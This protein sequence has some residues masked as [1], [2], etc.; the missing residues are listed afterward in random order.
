MRSNKLHICLNLIA[1]PNWHAGNI[2]IFNI[3]H[4]I[5]KLPD[6]ERSLVKLSIATR[7]LND[8]P[9]EIKHKVDKIYQEK[10]YHLIFYKVLR[11][12]PAF[13]RFPFFNF[14]SIDFYYPGG[15]LPKKWIF[16]WGGWIPD[17]QYRY[18]PQLFSKEEYDSRENRNVH[19]AKESPVL[20]FSSQNA[21]SDYHKFFPQYTGNEFLLRF[22]S[23]TNE[24]WLRQD[25]ISIQ[26]KYNLPDQFFIVCNQFWKHKDHPTIIDAIKILKDRGLNIIVVC[27]GATEDFRN[28]DY[29]PSLLKKAKELGVD[30]QFKVLGFI[31]RN[32]QIQLIRRSLAIIQPSL[33]EG[34]STVV[35][36]GRAL[37]KSIFLS[38]FSVHLEQNPPKVYFFKQQNAEELANLIEA[39][40]SSL[41]AQERPV[42]EDEVIALKQNEE[43][44]REFGRRIV[45]MAQSAK[46]N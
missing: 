19:L 22:V 34:W 13:L 36:D 40:Y 29:Y 44:M 16:N 33:F 4:A 12:L 1:D 26:K 25:A 17:F 37:G 18:L 38:D 43:A 45:L 39:N 21:L 15:N 30:N 2:Y 5:S 3:I 11:M 24:E 9:D 20:A 23:N 8:I 6:N 14:R 41:S 32:D 35:E 42:I 27:T 10:V 28:P 7:N 46:S 31:S